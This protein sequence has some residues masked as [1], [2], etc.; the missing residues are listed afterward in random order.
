MKKSLK[1]RRK[2]SSGGNLIYYVAEYNN[3]SENLLNL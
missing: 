1:G 3:W 2:F